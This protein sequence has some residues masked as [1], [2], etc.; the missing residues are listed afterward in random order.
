MKPKYA[1]PLL[2]LALLPAL[3][4]GGCASLGGEKPARVSVPEIVALAQEG[5]PP[6]AIIAK[7]R[8]SGTVYRLSA[9]QLADLRDKGVPGPVIDAMQQSY[10][11]AVRRDQ[12]Y[13]NW[14]RWNFDGGWWYGGWPYGWPGPWY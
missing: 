2:A 4:A 6:D 7:M 1:S 9:N 3:F 11:D 13:Q 14:N 12:R 8:A 10:L 5:V